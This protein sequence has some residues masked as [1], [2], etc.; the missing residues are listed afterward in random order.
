M[1]INDDSS[2][3]ILSSKTPE[4]NKNFISADEFP[5]VT[6]YNSTQKLTP[7]PALMKH[8]ATSQLVTNDNRISKTNQT[9]IPT[10]TVAPLPLPQENLQSRS[11]SPIKKPVFLSPNLEQI[12]RPES[13]EPQVDSVKMDKMS[14]PK[15]LLDPTLS[16]ISDLDPI[17]NSKS[18]NINAIKKPITSLNNS[19]VSRKPS[20]SLFGDFKDNGIDLPID[21]LHNAPNVDSP[22]KAVGAER[23][24][25]FKYL[26]TAIVLPNS[27]NS[28]PTSIIPTTSQSLVNTTIAKPIGSGSTNQL[29]SALVSPMQHPPPI[30][31][32]DSDSIVYIKTTP[33]PGLQN[34]SPLH[35]TSEINDANDQIKFQQNMYNPLVP[36]QCDELSSLINQTNPNMLHLLNFNL[37]P[38]STPNPV[39]TSNLLPNN[40]FSNYKQYVINNNIPFNSQSKLP[41]Q[42]FHQTTQINELNAIGSRS[43]APQQQ[44]KMNV[45]ALPQ[46]FQKFQVP[47]SIFNGSLNTQNIEYTMNFSSEKDSF[48]I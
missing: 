45:Q 7:P 29:P 15:T 21:S 6:V 24:I 1:K 9:K 14:N 22:K 42:N 2:N 19:N 12:V 11:L 40:G 16:I 30:L 48:K 41:N 27:V 35:L 4:A 25:G 3:K 34:L 43:K 38:N 17:V 13:V 46:L 28:V 8:T 44:N 36:G 47:S 31:L 18:I 26:P 37:P 39:N 32:D 20:S 10:Q 33:P 5:P 23:P